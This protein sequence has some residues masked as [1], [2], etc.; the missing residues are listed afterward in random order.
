MTPFIKNQCK[1]PF[2]EFSFAAFLLVVF[3]I[4]PGKTYSQDTLIAAQ[5]L[6]NLS[7]EELMNIEVTSVSKVPEKLTE[8]ASAIQVITQ[9]DIH[10]SAATSVPEA[11]R[12]ASNL[13]VTQ[14]N[15]R[16]WIISA[17]GF[18][19]TYSNKLL[20]MID[21]R[22]VYSPLFAGVFW[23][24]QQVLLEDVDRIEVI[25][26]PGGTLWG[27]NAVNG[28]INIITKNSKQTQGLYLSAGLG[29]E[30]KDIVE[31]RYGGRINPELSYRVYA[32][33]A[34]RN[35]TYLPDGNNNTDK[36]R[37]SQTGFNLDWDPSLQN[38]LSIRS[39]FYSG[40]DPSNSKQSSIDGQNAMGTWKHTFSEKSDLIIQAYADRTWR[41]EITSNIND[42]LYTYD[43]DFQHRFPL[44]KAHAII[45]GAGYRHMN[46]DTKNYT[47]FVGFIPASRKMNLYSSFIQ[48]EIS[49]LPGRLQLTVGTK[50]Q[51]NTF[52]GFE[53]QPTARLSFLPFRHHFLWAAVSRAVR[54]PSR[55]DVDY[56]IPVYDVPPTSPSVAGGPNFQSE[57]VL[58]YEA[59]YRVQPSSKISLSLATF[60]NQYYDLYSVEA[61]PGT[62]TYQIQNGAE[63]H[64][65]GTEFSGNFIPFNN[66]R[67][68]GGYTYF[69]KKLRNKPTNVTDPANLINLGRDAVH[70]AQLHSMLDISRN[71]QLDLTVRYISSLPASL[72][73][74]RVPDYFT[75]DS[76]IAWQF[77]KQLEISLNGQ[78]LL[79]KRHAETDQF[80]VQRGV[81]GKISWRL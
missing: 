36:W 10:R 67:L 79:D 33:H 20:V 71:L 23:D 4:L 28:V 43:L 61:L 69:Y 34:D 29:S 62:L 56:R 73:A 54:A 44:G 13:Q 72:Y 19:S 78:N 55:I 57:K 37:F 64:S 48:D 3:I 18:N 35:H 5:N 49:L 6:K 1:F 14:V 7:I 27:A 59:G 68:S 45:W 32:Q 74:K 77:K 8:V 38:T 66:W 17:R 12:L 9:Q 70:Q 15:S 42:E 22:T 11:L 51:H 76:R 50:L 39:N 80:E 65:Y 63:G 46:D 40:A 2:R 24:A 53:V 60:Y 16:H 75:L 26:G 30:L 47:D 58:A 41:K 52:T 21:G 31:A 25:S 81:Y